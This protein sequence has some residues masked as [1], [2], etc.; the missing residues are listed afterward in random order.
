MPGVNTQNQY[1]LDLE[2]AGWIKT[3]L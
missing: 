3:D 1:P 2:T